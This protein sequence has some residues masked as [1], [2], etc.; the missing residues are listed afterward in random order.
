M[1]FV[2]GDN[3]TNDIFEKINKQYCMTNKFGR[4]RQRTNNLRDELFRGS[5]PSCD[6]RLV[7]HCAN[8]TIYWLYIFSIK[9]ESV[10]IIDAL[11]LFIII[12]FC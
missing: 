1:A 11:I 9:K 4:R 10:A 12:R 8:D 5:I 2:K 6:K 7:Y 3:E